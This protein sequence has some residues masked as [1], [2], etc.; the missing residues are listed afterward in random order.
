ML[1][2][3]Q[4]KQEWLLRY[5]HANRRINLANEILSELI[6]V[7]P[8]AIEYSDMPKGSP[9]PAGLEVQ[10]VRLEAQI[11][12]VR[13]AE[14]YRD[15]VYREIYDT[16]QL[17]LTETQAEVMAY[18]YLAYKRS[19]YERLNGLEGTTFRSWPEIAR[20]MQLSVD[21]VAHIHGESLQKL[22]VDR[23]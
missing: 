13:R 7:G 10:A 8:K 22:K 1:P 17:Q 2:E 3:N 5:R 9:T 4:A 14:A 21:R 11:E 12:S 15:Q 18:R 16:L 23:S 20:I 6:T 19:E